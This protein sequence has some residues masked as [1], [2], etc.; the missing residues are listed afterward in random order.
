VP[1]QALALPFKTASAAG[2]T[3][4]DAMRD[5][6]LWPGVTLSAEPE[7]RPTFEYVLETFGPALWRVAGT[8]C[9]EAVSQQDLYQEI[10]VALWRALPRFRGEASL[11]TFVFRVAYNRGATYRLREHRRRTRELRLGILVDDVVDS[12]AVVSNRIEADSAA[13]R[14]RA[15]IA[16]LPAHLADVAVLRLEGLAP[17]QI[18]EVLGITTNNVNVRLHRARAQLRVILDPEDFR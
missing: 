17:D 11:K 15:V 8:H 14:L 9:H 6:Y 16:D 10:L 2:P 3:A 7:V 13:R 5:H 4:Q 1:R 18:S 12:K